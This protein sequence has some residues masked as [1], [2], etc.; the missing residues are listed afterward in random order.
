MTD[1]NISA[2]PSITLATTDD[3]LVINDANSV[4]SI[5]SWA[6][7]TGSI[8]GTDRSGFVL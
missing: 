1:I 3:M 8:S 2:L 5:I 4:T 6:D 7:L